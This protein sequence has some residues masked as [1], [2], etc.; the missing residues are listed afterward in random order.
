MIEKYPPAR[1][2][3]GSHE[4][5]R[6]SWY[7]SGIVRRDCRW[8]FG[9]RLISETRSIFSP[10]SLHSDSMIAQ[11]VWFSFLDWT[12]ASKK[13]TPCIWVLPVRCMWNTTT[14]KHC[15]SVVSEYGL[16]QNCQGMGWTKWNVSIV[17][18]GGTG[19]DT[20]RRILSLPHPVK[21]KIFL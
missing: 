8:R 18:R 10:S 12:N 7:L 13:C 14:Q 1:L 20:S 5:M 17:T 9:R 19:C 21:R 15:Q 6:G 16:N 11:F 3:D 2:D 4:R